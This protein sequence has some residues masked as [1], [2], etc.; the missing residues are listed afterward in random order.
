MRNFTKTAFALVVL[1]ALTAGGW[2]VG[3]QAAQMAQAG[4][5]TTAM[6]RADSPPEPGGPGPTDPNGPPN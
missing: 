1:G 5:I 4:T 3:M 2:V 6:Y